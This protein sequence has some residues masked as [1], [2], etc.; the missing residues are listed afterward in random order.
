MLI[1]YPKTKKAEQ[2]QEEISINNQNSIARRLYEYFN[3]H[4]FLSFIISSLPAIITTLITLFP[5]R[6]Q[7]S[8]NSYPFLEAVLLVLLSNSAIFT[9][10][11]LYFSAKESISDRE[12]LSVYKK[13]I[14]SIIGFENQ[15]TQEFKDLISENRYKSS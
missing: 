15:N 9:L 2:I 4:W 3:K 8:V 13:M 7:K 1:K 14:Q 12:R 5:E 11:N 6:Y 10:F